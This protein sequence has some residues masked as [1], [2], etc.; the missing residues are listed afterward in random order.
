MP[1]NG[2]AAILKASAANGASGRDGGS[3][4]SPRARVVAG[5]RRHVERRGQVV[6]DG[7]E[8]RLDAL[9]LQ[10]RAAQDR[11]DLVARACRRAARGGAGRRRPASP[12]RYLCAM[13]SSRSAS[14]STS[15]VAPA[16]GLGD[17]L[18]GDVADLD[19]VAQV[20]AVGDRL[21]V[22][23]VDHAAELVLGA[24][25]DLQRHGVRAEPVTDHVDHA[26]EVG[27]G[28]I[29]LVD[30]AEARHAVAGR[31]GARPSRTAAP[32]RPRRRTRRP[33]RRARAGSARP[34]P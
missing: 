26:P 4:S 17:E 27:A 9:V 1:T 29:E 23:Q 25:R 31:P 20:V 12:S 10:R 15:F 6:D 18:V 33:R 2:S 3:T 30:E 13:S 11:D 7:V 22:D 14:D 16:L 32:R 21:H 5:D 24:D 8:H 28:A 34:R 19:L